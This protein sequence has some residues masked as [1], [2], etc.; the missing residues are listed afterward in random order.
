MDVEPR[1]TKANCILAGNHVE[2]TDGDE[3]L[4]MLSAEAVR[5][6]GRPTQNLMERLILDMFVDWRAM[7][8]G[9]VQLLDQENWTL[10][11]SRWSDGDGVGV[12]RLGDQLHVSWSHPQSVSSH[13]RARAVDPV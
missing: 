12:R 5:A 6:A 13:L 10:T 1:S 9:G 8:K 2:A 7:Q 3:H 11:S 4:K